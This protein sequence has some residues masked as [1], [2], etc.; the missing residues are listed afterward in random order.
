MSTVI[1]IQARVGSTRLPNKVLTDI[2]GKPMLQHVIERCQKSS[3]ADAVMV[4]TTDNVHDD[5]IVALCESIGT[6]VYRGSE[7]DVLDRYKQAAEMIDADVIVRITS[8]CPLIDPEILD[9][10]IEVF[11]DEKPEYMSNVIE[12]TYPRG[13]DCEIFS[14]TV[15]E[16]VWNEATQKHER[17]HVT[18]YILENPEKFTVLSMKGERDESKHRWT[19]D[20]EE[21]LALVKAIYAELGAD[22]AFGWND[23][24]E[25]VENNPGLQQLNAAIEQ[26]SLKD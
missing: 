15:L 23:I 8:D 26:K 24:L 1:I 14:R 7:D 25:L 12:R 9:S 22:G 2:A 10:V 4:A 6:P 3:H 18:P 16:R 19:V 13:L 20:T 21:D 5:G 17:E 11:T